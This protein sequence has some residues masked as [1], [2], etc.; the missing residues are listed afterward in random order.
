MQLRNQVSKSCVRAEHDAYVD[1]RRYYMNCL[2]FR[3]STENTKRVT[4]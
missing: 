2:Q 4:V 3:N 1:V